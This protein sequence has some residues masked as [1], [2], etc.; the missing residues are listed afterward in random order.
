MSVQS[1]SCLA[2]HTQT[3]LF[4]RLGYQQISLP[5]NTGLVLFFLSLWHV[6]VSLSGGECLGFFRYV[7]FWTLC[8]A[9]PATLVFPAARKDKGLWV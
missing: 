8:C 7:E 1:P 5:L 6:G 9:S 2:C 3:V 4:G